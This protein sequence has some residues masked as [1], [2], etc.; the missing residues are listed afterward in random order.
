MISLD[1]SVVPDLGRAII[2]LMGGP[3]FLSSLET[4]LA[5]GLGAGAIVGA[6][7][8][9]VLGLASPKGRIVSSLLLGFTG[10]IGFANAFAF[11]FSIFDGNLRSSWNGLG[12]AMGGA[13]FGVT[14]ALYYKILDKMQLWRN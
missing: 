14:L 2:R 8:G 7:G 9:A 10:A 11:G 12:G 5:R 13:I 1:P 6:I 3:V 4:S